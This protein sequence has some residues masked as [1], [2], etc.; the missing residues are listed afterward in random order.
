[1]R[2]YIFAAL[3]LT[4]C[5]AMPSEEPDCPEGTTAVG[6]GCYAGVKRKQ[7]KSNKSLPSGVNPFKLFRLPSEPGCPEGTWAVGNDCCW[8]QYKCWEKAE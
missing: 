1:M 8:E 4:V 7:N 2:T 6:N 5:Q 3:V